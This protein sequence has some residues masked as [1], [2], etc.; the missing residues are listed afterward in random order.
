MF[1]ST[2]PYSYVAKGGVWYMGKG[3]NK[4]GKGQKMF[5]NSIDSKQWNWNVEVHSV[6]SQIIVAETLLAKSIIERLSKKYV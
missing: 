4:R 5:K 6:K 2:L 1:S 3:S